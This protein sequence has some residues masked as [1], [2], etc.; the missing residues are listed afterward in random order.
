VRAA[1]WTACIIVVAGAALAAVAFFE[2]PGWIVDDGLPAA[3]RLMLENSV[4]TT[5]IEVVGGL[6]ALAG[7]A[8][9]IVGAARTLAHEREVRITQRFN[10]A[11]EGIA[12][13]ESNPR[14][15]GAAHALARVALDSERDRPAAVAVMLA[16]LRENA[17]WNP[18]TDSAQTGR[19]NPEVRSFARDI[20]SVLARS[21]KIDGLD[22]SG[23][24]FEGA[25][26]PRIELAAI[27]LRNTN[28]SGA[29][30]TGVTLSRSQL[31]G[32]YCMGTNFSGAVLGSEVRERAAVMRHTRLAGAVFRGADLRNCDFSGAT[33][34]PGTDFRAADLRGAIGLPAQFRHDSSTKLPDAA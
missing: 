10:E 1:I 30:L 18:T 14:R 34:D 6:V 26:L 13:G 25:R 29:D 27:D 33:L 21:G 5:A 11:L 3:D 9:T 15:I 32:C 7:A 17:P 19:T 22:L 24:N 20:V 23:I 28:L 12:D 2:L 16:S 31:Q 8:A 4:R